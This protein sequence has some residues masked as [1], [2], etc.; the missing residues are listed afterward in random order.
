MKK[1][2][3]KLTI[4]ATLSYSTTFGAYIGLP[5]IPEIGISGTPHNGSGF[6]L[7]P[8][9]LSFSPYSHKRY[10]VSVDFPVF[11]VNGLGF[12]P[13]PWVK[14]NLI[15]NNKDVDAENLI[16]EY[17]D[18]AYKINIF[19]ASFVNLEYDA[20]GNR[21]FYYFAGLGYGGQVG[22]AKDAR[23][24]AKVFPTIS[25]LQDLTQDE[26]LEKAQDPQFQADL[27][28]SL[29]S[30]S[31]VID[32]LY[33]TNSAAVIT[34]IKELQ[35]DPTI[36]EDEDKLNAWLNESKEVVE[37]LDLSAGD[38]DITK[39]VK[40]N[41]LSMNT[42]VA[43]QLGAGY[44]LKILGPLGLDVRAKMQGLF[45]SNTTP[46]YSVGARFIFKW[47]SAYKR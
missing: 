27:L 12:N 16:S 39:A 25:K 14:K 31:S 33:G 43:Y 23:N 30:L 13:Y 5:L 11:H 6:Y 36:I 18:I 24:I 45:N 2:L 3:T 47:G 9:N 21:G 34:K 41:I 1:F 29:D 20:F 4:L 42:G 7:A 37:D 35:A 44:D 19:A 8:F 32:N 40:E 10:A 28:E 46:V 22:I 26:L 15:D 17:G 38:I